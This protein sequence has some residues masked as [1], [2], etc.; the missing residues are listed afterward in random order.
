MNLN[1]QQRLSNLTD[2]SMISA[3]PGAFQQEQAR[4]KQLFAQTEI[5][6]TGGQ[7]PQNKLAAFQKTSSGDWQQNQPMFMQQPPQYMLQQQQQQQ[8]QQPMN[9][10]APQQFPMH[11][12]Q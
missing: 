9:N 2:N 10:M 5:N 1:K 3:A 8:M 6:E 12:D 11:A 4:Q 7:I